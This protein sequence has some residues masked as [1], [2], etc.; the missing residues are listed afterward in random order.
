MSGKYGNLLAVSL[1]IT[2]ILF[3]A[4]ILCGA[5]AWAASPSAQAKVTVSDGAVIRASYSTESKKVGTLSADETFKVTKEVFTSS[6]STRASKRWYYSSGDK[7]YVRG[8][9]VS[10]KDGTAVPG[11]TTDYVNIRKGA[12]TG[13][14]KVKVLKSGQKV[15]VVLKAYSS[16]GELWYRIKSG[17]QFYYLSGKYVKLSSSTAPAASSEESTDNKKTETKK[18]ETA[19]SSESGRDVIESNGFPS[20]YNALLKEL[21]KKHPNWVFRPV[22]TGL[23]WDQA[24]AKMTANPGT[25]TIYSTF[26][27]SFRSTNRGCYNYL[28][29]TYSPKDGNN[30]YAASKQA[31][32]YFMDPRN[33]LDDTHIFMFEDEGY[34]SSYQKESVVKA[35]FDGRNNTLKKHSASFIRAAKDY[36]INAIYLAAKALEEQGSTVYSR[37]GTY[38]VFNIGAY[39][40]SSGGVS[41]GMSF[42]R[43]GSSYLRPWNSIDLSI[44]GGAKYIA[45]NFMGNKQDS[46]YLEHFNVRNGLSNVGTH[47]YMTAVYA[48]RNTATS[49]SQ[50][51]SKYGIYNKKIVFYI[52]VYKN[53]P[54]KLCSKP[55]GSMKADNNYYLKTLKVRTGGT[56]HTLISSSSLNYSKSFSVNTGSA[57]T[58]SI[59]ASKASTTG[60]VITGAGTKELEKGTNTFKIKVKASSGKTRTYTVK[61]NRY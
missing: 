58:A 1:M 19:S 17:S 48:P 42:A 36:D 57:R 56:T 30:F 4:M 44:R 61:I 60:A 13:F 50:S 14:S 25:N 59:T 21:S 11:V 32:Y 47:V 6:S 26:A 15:N 34:Q 24:K 18:E 22:Q 31:V 35:V 10:M 8:D 41:N 37:N 49:T 2:G 23:D 29:H 46:A 55:S 43:S 20:T 16:K 27:W 5:D 51:Y 45:S 9:L 39:D 40:S 28:R 54:R 53:M 12:G 7:G 3:L 38:N 52:P 33:W